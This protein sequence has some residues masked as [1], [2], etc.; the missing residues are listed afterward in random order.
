MRLALGRGPSAF[1]PHIAGDRFDDRCRG[2]WRSRLRPRDRFDGCGR[3][4]VR[5]LD[6]EIRGKRPEARR[7][8]RD[9][10]GSDRFFDHG[11]RCRLGIDRV[12]DRHFQLAGEIEFEGIDS[13]RGFGSGLLGRHIQLERGIEVV[14]TGGKGRRLAGLDRLGLDRHGFRLD[15]LDEG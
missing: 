3:L 6:I 13:R 7:W 12:A 8:R 1:L 4:Q 14:G 10:F 15:R 9:G 11:H 5:T 2:H